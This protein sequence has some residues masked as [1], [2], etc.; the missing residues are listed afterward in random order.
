MVALDGVQ[1]K[2]TLF[3]LTLI[4]KTMKKLMLTIL[5]AFMGIVNAMAQEADSLQTQQTDVI[6]DSVTIAKYHKLQRDFDFLS[7]DFKITTL[8]DDLKNFTQ[9]IKIS[10]LEAR[11][12]SYHGSFNYDLY[13]AYKENLNIDKKLLEG[14]KE[15]VESVKMF[16][17]VKMFV[18]DFSESEKQVLTNSI[19]MFDRHLGAAERA[20]KIYEIAIDMYGR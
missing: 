11:V 12:N 3:C 4:Y 10:S 13:K 1:D 6:V 20:L 8:I 14:Y 2:C 9:D 16:T 19:D 18:S 5:I 15:R 17:S 7:C